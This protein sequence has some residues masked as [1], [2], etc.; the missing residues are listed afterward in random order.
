MSRNGKINYNDMTNKNV[1][2]NFSLF[3]RIKKYRY[4]NVI[5]FWLRWFYPKSKGIPLVFLLYY[6]IPQKILRINGNVLWPVHFT[7][8]VSFRK[9]IK[10]GNRTAPGLSPGCYI[11]GRGGIIIG[12][13]VRIAP[14]VGIISSNHRLEDYDLWDEIQPIE[15]GD[16][17]WIGMNSVILQG[18]KIGDNV[19]IG[20]NSVVNKDIPANSIAA[21]NPCRIIKE[22]GP[23]IGRDYSK[24]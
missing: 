3:Q 5:L 1:G 4:L 22:K 7:S 23:Y 19:V 16:N 18:V 11:Q 8:K 20:C 17:V 14:N 13:N 2:D 9:N 6:F 10:I 15:I 12:N 24:M 21:G